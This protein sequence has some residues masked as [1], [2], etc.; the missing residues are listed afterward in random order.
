MNDDG[1]DERKRQLKEEDR[2]EA[3]LREDE[4]EQ[5]AGN[6]ESSPQ[7]TDVGVKDSVLLAAI[8]ANH[9]E[10]TANFDSSNTQ[11]RDAEGSNNGDFDSTAVPGAHSSPESDLVS[12]IGVTG[13]SIP[14]AI[15]PKASNPFD[16][17][18]SPK[19]P[20]DRGRRVIESSS[21]NPFA[22]DDE[23]A[24]SLTASN[25]ATS[26]S[27]SQS[28]LARAN[29]SHGRNPFDDEEKN[30][31]NS[32]SV[33]ASGTQVSAV[34]P[35]PSGTNQS[36]SIGDI[37]PSDDAAENAEVRSGSRVSSSEVPQKTLL[38]LEQKVNFLILM[39]FNPK[40]A[41]RAI[42]VN[43]SLRAAVKVLGYEASLREG[44]SL[45]GDGMFVW[46]PPISATVGKFFL[47][48]Y[49]TLLSYRLSETS[50]FVR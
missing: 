7:L 44:Q 42:E 19:V 22:G 21:S 5:G 18:E 8:A 23:T 37:A 25:Y 28:N 31:L 36:T 32:A 10:A 1:V 20:D 27:I 46:K 11:H 35:I 2:L 3:L 9:D 14:E 33:V 48:F 39:G 16:E 26:A 13:T 47:I 34:I 24:D 6:E 17:D 15:D 30:E 45:R 38:T 12:K 49:H 50:R 4:G 41:A 43:N 40:A 29:H